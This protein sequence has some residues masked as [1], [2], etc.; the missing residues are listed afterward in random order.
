MPTAVG[1]LRGH[2]IAAAHYHAPVVGDDVPLK[3]LSI[4]PVDQP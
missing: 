2:E 1:V 4:D 3:R